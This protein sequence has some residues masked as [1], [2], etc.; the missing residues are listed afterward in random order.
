MKTNTPR[1]KASNTNY[2]KRRGRPTAPP[3][4]N[5]QRNRYGCGGKIKK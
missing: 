3:M 1:P 4:L 2:N 5:R